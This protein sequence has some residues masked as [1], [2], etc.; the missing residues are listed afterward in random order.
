MRPEE[1]EAFFRHLERGVVPPTAPC[2]P[3]VEAFI[4]LDWDERM[5]WHR[6]TEKCREHGMYLLVALDWV[7]EFV[8]KFALRSRTLLEVGAGRGWLAAALRQCGV[9]VIATDIEPPH[10]ALVDV[11]RLDA[12]EAVRRYATDTSGLLIAWPPYRN[13]M[14]ARAVREWRQAGFPGPVFYLGE[15]PGGATATPAFWQVVRNLPCEVMEVLP[16]WPGL[17]DQLWVFTLPAGT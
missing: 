13:D 8:E 10:N 12:E 9:H 16:R 3:P 14:A 11:V 7:R 5:R 6:A 2:I 4:R 15:G 1:L 17:H